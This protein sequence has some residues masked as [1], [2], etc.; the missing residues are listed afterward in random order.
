M[1]PNRLLL[2]LILGLLVFIAVHVSSSPSDNAAYSTSEGSGPQV[3]TRT[4]KAAPSTASP[5]GQSSSSDMPPEGAIDFAC[6]LLPPTGAPG[7]SVLV[8]QQIG[9]DPSNW[10]RAPMADNGCRAWRYRVDVPEKRLE[11]PVPEGTQVEVFDNG[12][13]VLHPGH[14]AGSTDFVI[15]W[16][17][18]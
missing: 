16:L 8:A 1:P 18:P 12:D 3:S 4:D 15:S 11:F 9:G 13:L 7:T 2:L 14:I 5:A 6:A 10:T 17:G